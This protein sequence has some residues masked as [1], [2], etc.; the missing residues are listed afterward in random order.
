MVVLL[1]ALSFCWNVFASLS[2]HSFFLAAGLA[3]EVLK[4]NGSAGLSNSCDDFNIYV[5][6]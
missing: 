4:A 2:F 5:L 6:N 1:I 3:G